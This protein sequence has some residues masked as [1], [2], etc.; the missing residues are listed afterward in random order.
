[1][2]FAENHG[3]R[4]FLVSVI[5]I[6]SKNTTCNLNCE[7]MDDL[8]QEAQ[9]SLGKAARIPLTSEAQPP[10]SRHGEKVNCQRWD[11]SMHAML[12]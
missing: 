7:N 9:L 12:T 2:A 6:V 5:F 11:S 4:D 8:W 3:F 10:I 1:M